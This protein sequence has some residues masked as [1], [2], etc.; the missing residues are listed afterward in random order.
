MKERDKMKTLPQLARIT[1]LSDRTLRHYE[2]I[3]LL[4]PTTRNESGV[5]LYAYPEQLRL[6]QILVFKMFGFALKD[7]K[8]LLDSET[9]EIKSSLEKQLKMLQHEHKRLSGVIETLQKTIQSIKEERKMDTNKL[10]ENFPDMEKYRSEAIEKWGEEVTQVEERLQ[11]LDKQ[12]TQALMEEGLAISRM[13]AG[14]MQNPAS[15]ENTQRLIRLH[16]KYMQKFYEVPKERYI[17]LAEMY[18]GDARFTKYYED[19]APGLANY[20]SDG[21]KYFAEK[22]L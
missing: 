11:K 9:Y 12:D 16:Y 1:G 2:K 6:Q 4:E 13:I 17:G 5:R 21:M 8:E 3:G 7:I 22:N 18:L 20:I 14:E 10:Y 15:S 19:I